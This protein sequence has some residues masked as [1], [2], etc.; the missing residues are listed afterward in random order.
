M[1][2]CMCVCT[3]MMCVCMCVWGVCTRCVHRMC[4]HRRVCLCVYG[5]CVFVCVC[6]CFCVCVCVCVC[7]LLVCAWLYDHNG[8]VKPTLPQVNCV[9]Y[10]L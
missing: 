5:V 6:V 8:Y 1:C 10:S 3:C 2:V 4:M 9:N 7:E